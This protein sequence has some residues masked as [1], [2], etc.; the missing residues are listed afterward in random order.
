MNGLLG[1]L[2]ILTQSKH[3][4]FHRLK[5]VRIAISFPVDR[6]AGTREVVLMVRMNWCREDELEAIGVC[7]KRLTEQI[8]G[9]DLIDQLWLFN[10]DE[11]GIVLVKK[12]Q[13]VAFGLHI[14]HASHVRITEQ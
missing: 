10:D 1:C 12:K 4:D 13:N 7:L 14:L 2:E 11:F 3:R 6:Q 5:R 8:G 9:M